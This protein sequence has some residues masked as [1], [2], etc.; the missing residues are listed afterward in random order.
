MLSRLSAKKNRVNEFASLGWLVCG[1][2]LLSS[3]LQN[4]TLPKA[5]FLETLDLNKDVEEKSSELLF[6]RQTVFE[7]TAPP[8]K[9]ASLSMATFDFDWLKAIDSRLFCLL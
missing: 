5:P 9:K 1:Q 7:K 3:S 6:S 4:L 2:L 8:W